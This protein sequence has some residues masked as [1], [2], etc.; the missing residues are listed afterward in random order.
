[1]KNILLFTFFS[2]FLNAPTGVFNGVLKYESDYDMAGQVGKVL[3]T[4]YENDSK[5]RIE[6]T[7][8]L[9]KTSIGTPTTKDQNVILYDFSKQQETQL[10]ALT[11]RAIVGPYLETLYRQSKQGE[12]FLDAIKVDVQ[13]LGNEKVGEYNC[14]HFVVSKLN[15]K[16]KPSAFNPA[17]TD[18]WVTQDLGSCRIWYVGSYLYYP[19]GSDTQKK[20]ADAGVNGVVVK[21]HTG[22]GSLQ[23]SAMLMSYEKKNLP[24]STFTPPSNFTVVQPDMSAIPQKN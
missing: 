16:M 7:N 9:T 11:S 4:I 23:N 5:G 20:L 6:S 21:W 22:T 18:L 17:K 19:E 12:S 24:S 2:F 10:Q 15:T 14:T 8:I 1:M 3:T 13:N